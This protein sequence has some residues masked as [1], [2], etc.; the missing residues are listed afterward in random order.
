MMRFFTPFSMVA[1]VAMVLAKGPD[2]FH[3]PADVSEAGVNPQ[4]V[5]AIDAVLQSFIDD[6]KLS[7][8]VGFIAKGGQVVYHRAFGWKDVENRVPATIDDYYVL[9]SQT[10]AVVTVAFMTLVEEGLVAIDDPV[11]KYFPEV[12]DEVVTAVHADGSYET[13][14][15]ATPM[16]FVHLMTHTSGLNAGLVRE[17]RQA[18]RRGDDAPAGFGGVMP[19]ETPSGQHSGGGNYE[20]QYLEEEMLAL[21]AYP[22]GFDPGT[23]WDYHVST[24]MLAYLIERISGKPLRQYVKEAVLEPLG[25][26]E[27]DWY[28][29]P[30][31]LAR[32]VKAY[33]AIDGRLEPGSNL[34]S[35][36]TV[37]REQTYAEGAIGLN[38]PIADYARFC[39]MLLNTGTF[40]GHRILQPETIEQMTRINR[41]PENSGAE[42][43]FQF[44]LGFELHGEKKPVP[45][46][47]DAAFAWGGMLGTAYL[48]DPE[49]DLIVLFYTNMFGAGNVFPLFLEKAYSLVMPH[50]PAREGEESATVMLENGG[51]GPHTAV[52]TED[53]SFPGMTIFRPRDLTAFGPAERLPILLWGNGACANTTQEHKL[54]LNELAS[55]GYVI[56][57]IGRLDQIEERDER[58]RE[59]TSSSQLLDMLDWMLAQHAS[60]ESAYY[61][62]VDPL[63][64]AA[65]GM[66]C[67]GLQ[68]IEISGDPRIRTT[69]VAN[70]GVLPEPSPKWG[71]PP[72][73]KDALRDF[74]GPVL[75]LMG[76][77]S[78]IA[79]ANAM[80]DFRRVQQV[81][82]VM[83]NLD[84][85]H[86]GT[87]H[88]PHGGEY[89]P[90]ALAWL[91][92]QLKGDPEASALFLNEKSELR[93]NPEWSIEV[94]NFPAD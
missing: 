50:D 4:A 27:T 44:G 3:Y 66:S 41:L 2:A 70:S 57:A 85:G 33:R 59:M 36:G 34:Y 15:T 52:V 68:A 71:M 45:A 54:F 39:Q 28:Y 80:D 11:A 84:V 76:G 26:E 14:P 78:D 16:T 47:S 37:S 43:G 8:A 23:R 30:D 86:G 24:N 1:L 46:V 6:Q 49:H 74:H 89:T 61:G 25:M 82:V 83:A 5:E 63:Q 88:R 17:I 55:H 7:S 20:A 22:L 72:L 87:Y 51:R 10:K 42:A 12:P 67:G 19:N 77:P 64:V 38:G 92:W 60:P 58:S 56:L 48:I 53:A 81:P 13:R 69:V 73:S 90:V 32:F 93:R 31:A 9:F 91:D 62:R 29:E 65:M 21:A 94:K 75:Y 40:N 35:E 79:Y 18:E